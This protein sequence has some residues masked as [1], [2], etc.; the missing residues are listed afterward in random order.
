[1][2][3]EGRVPAADLQTLIAELEERGWL[4]RVR[5]A[6]DPALEITEITDRVTKAGGPALLF[7]H[8]KG[9]DIPLLINTFGTR[10][11]M[12]LAL[13]CSDFDELAAR[14]RSL[15]RPEIPTTLMQKLRKLPELAQLGSLP[16][17]VVQRGV[18]QEVVRTADA[19][20]FTLPAL[21]CWPQDGGRYITLGA[22]FTKN[23]ATG[24]RNV[25]L[26]RV[27]IFEPKLAA[28]HW[29]IHHDGARHFRLY[30]Q[31]GQ[32]M[33]LAIALGGPAVLPY[34][35]TCPLP[36]GLDECLFAGFL[37]GQALELVPCVSQPEIEVPATAEIVIEGYVDPREELILEG[38]FGDHTG[39]YSLPDY[40][41]RFHVTALTH[42]RRPIYPT[43]IVGK[44][45][46]EDYWL[47]K[48]TERIFL[49]LLQT[50]VPDIIDYDLPQFGCFH[51]CAFVKIKKEY[52][53]QARRVM[54]ALWGVGQMAL[55]KII[56]VVD[57]HVDVH[58][59]DEVLF[60]LCSNVDPQRDV[61]TVAGPV[62]ILDH[63][64]PACG[65][66]SK[67]GIDAT[68]KIAGEG[69]VRAW[70][71]ELQMSRE[72]VDLVT[73]RWSEYGV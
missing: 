56:V 12:C 19:D 15:L 50:L 69:P 60:Q 46:Q 63:A 26:Y 41:P 7:E 67:L 30:Q 22:V 39:F 10:Q 9:T 6:V 17:K 43:T 20:L 23:P 33:P 45:P 28:M 55:T 73:R 72:I 5:A 34:A 40:Y 53:F 37:Q 62:D 52:A 8:V 27:Q 24:D 32:R 31:C 11:R 51:N 71:D 36:P 25:G 2:A 48:A 13:G 42:R 18:C 68:R 57:E 4:K 47:G 49:P 16:P 59:Q 61:V 65:A 29:H 21:T 66:G 64:A 14:V 58:N 1:V 70:P 3:K 44:P 54:Y 38:P 35:A